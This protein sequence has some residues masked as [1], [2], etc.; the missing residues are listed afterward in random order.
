MDRFV[1]RRMPPPVS[2]GDGD[3]DGDAKDC[4]PKSETIG[5]A[6]AMDRFVVRGT[7]RIRDGD[8]DGV[9]DAKGYPKSVGKTGAMDR[10]VVRGKL[11]LV[12]HRSGDGIDCGGR[13]IVRRRHISA[14]EWQT[15]SRLTLNARLG[16]LQ[17]LLQ[18]YSQTLALCPPFLESPQVAFPL[19]AATPAPR[20]YISN[21]A[22]HPASCSA[23]RLAAATSTGLLAVY[24]T[25]H[26][27]SSAHDL[28]PVLECRVGSNGAEG[29]AWEGARTA[30]Q[31]ALVDGTSSVHLCSFTEAS[32]RFSR[33]SLAPSR[34]QL[35]SS[36]PM[37]S[38]SDVA[39]LPSYSSCVAA[40]TASRA[41]VWDVRASL[42]SP[43]ILFRLPDTRRAAATATTA[44]KCLAADPD[45]SVI[46][47][48]CSDGS[49]CAW[50]MRQGTGNHQPPP[51]S[52]SLQSLAAD[53]SQSQGAWNHQPLPLPRPT[54]Q[55]QCATPEAEGTMAVGTRGA[56][57]ALRA[58]GN[59]GSG[60]SGKGEGGRSGGG[61]VEGVASGEGSGVA[62]KGGG[63]MGKEEGVLKE[64]ER[65]IDWEIGVRRGA[66]GLWSRAKEGARECGGGL[67]QGEGSS[68]ESEGGLGER[69]REGEGERESEREG[70]GEGESER[71]RE[72][73]LREGRREMQS[74]AEC[75]D[76]SARECASGNDM[77]RA[78]GDVRVGGQG[79][80]VEARIQSERATTG[81]V[82]GRE[83]PEHRIQELGIG[84]E[85]RGDSN[86]TRDS[87]NRCGNFSSSL[88]GGGVSSSSKSRARESARAALEGMRKK[89]K[90][91]GTG[92][93]AGTGAGMEVD[94]CLELNIE[95]G[96]AKVQEMGQVRGAM[97]HDW[98]GGSMGFNRAAVAWGAK[99]SAPFT[100][101][102]LL[103]AQ[104]WSESVWGC[105]RAS[106]ISYARHSSGDCASHHQVTISSR[107]NT[108]G[109]ETRLGR[110]SLDH[111]S[112]S[113]GG[114]AGRLEVGA[115]VGGGSVRVGMDGGE[116]EH[117]EA[118][119]AAV[120]RESISAAAVTTAAAGLG[121]AALGVGGAV[122]GGAAAAAAA[123][124][125]QTA[126]RGGT[127]TREGG[128]CR[129]EDSH[130]RHVG[131]QWQG[132][133][134]QRTLREGGGAGGAGG[135]MKA[136]GNSARRRSPAVQSAP[137]LFGG[138]PSASS[139][140]CFGR[141]HGALPLHLFST[142]HLFGSVPSL[143]EQ[144]GMTSSAVQ[145]ISFDPASASRLSFHLNNGWSGV[146]HVPSLSLS[147]IHCPPPPWVSTRLEEDENLGEQ[148]H[149]QLAPPVVDPWRWRLLTRR[150]P[151]WL[152][153]SVLCVPSAR[154]PHLFF[155][156]LG[157]GSPHAT[158]CSSALNQGLAP[159]KPHY[160]ART[161]RSTHI[162]AVTAP[163]AAVAAAPNGLDVIASTIDGAMVVVSP[164]LPA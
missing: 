104:G 66:G 26:H 133:A 41:A 71:G 12:G 137:S 83:G 63:K 69:E 127:G 27:I 60:R 136:A 68:R 74:A 101:T 9:G 100:P 17:Q 102:D 10:F 7:P 112:R 95:R 163:L 76:S 2:D 32:H 3:G 106:R 150:T 70:E 94:G 59:V 111:S 135:G 97:I 64:V 130:G 40:S 79:M 42:T 14:L 92:M 143:Q 4:H 158:P 36:A 128:G 39:F 139:A 113:R 81:G 159:S 72:R 49:I 120:P 153:N 93:G 161:S 122:S 58:Q 155:L 164:F 142:S 30:G 23:P 33:L 84:E 129:V 43:A 109:S 96:F 89:T 157:S 54:S 48:G 87:S 156:D 28:S 65:D 78:S 132:K 47:G 53:N 1:V 162:A 148:H 88:N 123:A 16:A 98:V 121:A 116:G 56:Q 62:E 80:A 22:F 134:E 131:M 37:P 145:H 151:A 46:Y 119:R 114:P 50:E 82:K 138:T 105:S 140:F 124:D 107:D 45:A 19:R 110:S 75:A 13:R 52:S 90:G 117:R 149:P 20:P 15:T 73:D 146:L 29:M 160:K 144:A 99:K 152:P 18:S 147:H 34:I 11:P 8:G 91:T 126:E 154:D 77:G 51:L 44:I 85:R 25:P 125:R 86:G 31:I 61:S 118:G 24:S 55:Q 141:E 35:L 115:R 5:R 103:G 57:K 21:L 38:F 67:R 108:G 6:G